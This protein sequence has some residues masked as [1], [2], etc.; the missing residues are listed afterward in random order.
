MVHQLKSQPIETVAVLFE[1]IST[2]QEEFAN[3]D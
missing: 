1:M 2:F 3:H